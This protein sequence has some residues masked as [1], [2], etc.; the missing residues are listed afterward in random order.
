MTLKAWQENWTVVRHYR[1]NGVTFY[2]INTPCGSIAEYLTPGDARLMAAAPEMARLL[3][4]ILESEYT[5][6]DGPLEPVG[7]RILEVL[8]KAGVTT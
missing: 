3:V 5:G 4:S 2:A 8:E 7:T 6:P 1:D